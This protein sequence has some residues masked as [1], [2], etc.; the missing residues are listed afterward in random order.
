MSLRKRGYNESSKTVKI[1]NRYR[2][3]RVMFDSRDE[4]M[5]ASTF[6]NDQTKSLKCSYFRMGPVWGIE[7]N[8]ID[9]PMFLS[10][11]KKGKF[12]PLMP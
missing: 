11:L 10:L 3:P 12:R 4:A 2:N 6:I 1:V 5:K 8:E 7:A 9:L